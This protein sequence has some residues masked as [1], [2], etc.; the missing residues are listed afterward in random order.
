MGSAV[1]ASA[2]IAVAS[3]AQTEWEEFI[4]DVEALVARPD[5]CNQIRNWKTIIQSHA[6]ILEDLKH[7]RKASEWVF[8]LLADT[9]LD[10]D[11]KETVQTDVLQY[12]SDEFQWEKNHYQLLHRFGEQRTSAV[13]SCLDEQR[14]DTTIRLVAGAGSVLTL[15]VIACGY[16]G[17]SFVAVVLIAAVFGSARRLYVR[18]WQMKRQ[19]FTNGGD[20]SFMNDNKY[21]YVGFIYVVACFVEALFYGLGW[22]IRYGVSALT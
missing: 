3:P 1:P 15:L 4:A 21:V 2:T 10:R 20:A 9:R 16:F 7:R 17:V 6:S 8:C 11:A 5:K 19:G 18:Q 13:F 14:V 22:V 12:L